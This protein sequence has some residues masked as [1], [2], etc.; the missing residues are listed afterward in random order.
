[1]VKKVSVFRI[2][3]QPIAHSTN[4]FNI[5]G[6]PWVFFQCLPEPTDMH[7]QRSGISGIFCLPNRLKQL[8]AVN[9]LART[10][11]QG[12][13]QIHQSRELIAR[14]VYYI[15]PNGFLPQGVKVQQPINRLPSSAGSR[16]RIRFSSFWIVNGS[17]KTAFASKSS[18]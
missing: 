4:R 14:A 16:G 9:H 12:F 3:I 18:R 1:M 5:P 11:H 10:F 7:I 15:A 17:T 6:M 13:Q 2:N 8:C